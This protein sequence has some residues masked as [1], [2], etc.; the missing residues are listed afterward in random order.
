M[1]A[2]QSSAPDDPLSPCINVCRMDPVTGLCEG[3]YRTLD[4][5]AEWSSLGES[6]KRAVLALL[7]ARKPRQ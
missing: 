7:P 2:P 5:I 3:C 6:E 4:E 1:A